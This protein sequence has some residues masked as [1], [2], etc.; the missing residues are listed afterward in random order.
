MYERNHRPYGITYLSADKNYIEYHADPASPL[1]AMCKRLVDATKE[2]QRKDYLSRPSWISFIKHGMLHFTL[3][4]GIYPIL[5]V[6]NA[7]PGVWGAV[8]ISNM[9]YAFILWYYSF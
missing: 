3:M 5:F 4:A 7:E 8:F 1:S 6:Y 9:I 2:K